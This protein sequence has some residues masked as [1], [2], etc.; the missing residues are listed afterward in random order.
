MA[1]KNSLYTNTH[2][3]S[4][5]T[6]TKRREPDTPNHFN[7]TASKSRKQTVKKKCQS[8]NKNYYS[9]EY[10]LPA[11]PLFRTS[12]SEKYHDTFFIVILYFFFNSRSLSPHFLRHTLAFVTSS[13]PS[14]N[15]FHNFIFHHHHH[16]IIILFFSRLL[17]P[18][19]VAFLCSWWRGQCQHIIHCL[20]LIR[21]HSLPWQILFDL[22]TI[23]IINI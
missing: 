10:L 19:S 11:E 23:M 3:S 12:T 4:V 21:W 15:I 17:I 16:S 6:H 9:N 20:P 7:L 5:S 8:G 1:H 22:S 2:N 18:F 14:H 13:L